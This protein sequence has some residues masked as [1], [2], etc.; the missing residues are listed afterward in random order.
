MSIE[1]KYNWNFVDI[2]R[3]IF[4]F[5]QCYITNKNEEEHNFDFTPHSTEAT[6][7]STKNLILPKCFDSNFGQQVVRR[8]TGIFWL[9]LWRQANS[10]PRHSQV[11]PFSGRG[12][13]WE[14]RG[15]EDFWRSLPLDLINISE[16]I[17]N[18]RAWRALTLSYE[19]KARSIAA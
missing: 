17:Q 14:W 6:V 16:G 9:I 4:F 10:S 18:A 5:V 2:K 13:E 3:K 11:Q 19:R 12:K 7:I 8:G 15:R 1:T